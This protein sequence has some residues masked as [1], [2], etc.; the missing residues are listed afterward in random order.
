MGQPPDLKDYL[1]KRGLAIF[2]SLLGIGFLIVGIMG[3]VNAPPAKPDAQVIAL[4][5][6]IAN[7]PGK[8]IHVDIT[9]LLVTHS[10]ADQLIKKAGKEQK[11]VWVPL[12]EPDGPYVQMIQKLSIDNPELIRSGKLPPPKIISIL[13]KSDH[14]ADD[15]IDAGPEATLAALLGETPGQEGPLTKTSLQI[16]RFI[17]GMIINDIEPLNGA[18]RKFLTEHYPGINLDKVLI[19]DHE[20]QPPRATRNIIMVSIGLGLLFFGIVIILIP[21]RKDRSTKITPITDNPENPA[22]PGSPENT[23]NIDTPASTES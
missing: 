21:K 8:N 23:G 5:D 2:L 15:P 22:S 18:D 19:F 11:I 6:L 7:G 17:K 16:Q 9:H 10:F 1:M 12:V 20:R 3:F 4:K 14:V 13:L